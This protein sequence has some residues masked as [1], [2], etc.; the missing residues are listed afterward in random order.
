MKV[1]K[2][3]A[4]CLFLLVLL[5]SC[6]NPPEFDVKPSITMDKL[7]YIER[8][9]ETGDNSLSIVLNFK[10]G[11]GDLGLNPQLP[12]HQEAPFNYVDYYQSDAQ[13]GFNKAGFQVVS[14]T[15]SSQFYNL[16]TTSNPAKGSLIYYSTRKTNPLEYG[17]LPDFE[18]TDY[19]TNDFLI[20]KSDKALLGPYSQVKDTLT[21][22]AHNIYYLVYDSVYVKRNPNHY[23]IDVDILIQKGSEWVPF[24]LSF[25][26]TTFYGRFP[27]LGDGN[28]ALEGTL[29]YDM[30][31]SAWDI[32]FGGKLLKLRIKIRDRALHESNEIITEN[33]FTLQGIR[34]KL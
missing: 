19:E 11:D 12:E 34:G 10:D 20:R 5:G 7:V 29:R 15:T 13:G 30:V 25:L 14:G 16:I 26:C 17:S 21:D 8:F 33:A 32:L 4:I 2:G 24:D 31:S 28:S 1:I 6:F 3:L 27:V 23:N 18:C 22:N 9:T